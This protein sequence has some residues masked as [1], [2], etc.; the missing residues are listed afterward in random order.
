MTIF[1]VIPVVY[2]CEQIVNLAK[3]KPNILKNIAKYGIIH[4]TYGNEFKLYVK[5]NGGDLM[6]AT[7]MYIIWAVAIV[8]FG[9]LEGITFQLVSIWFMIGSVAGLVAA[10]CS[11]PF[12]L[13]VIISIAVSVLALIVTRPIVMKYLKPRIQ[14]TNADR[15]IDQWAVVLEEIDNIKSTGCVKVDG[16]EWTARSSDG[17][18]I[19]KDA[20]VTVEKIEGV[21]LIV[22]S[23]Q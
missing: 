18:V 7:T 5:S 19:P 10:L 6:E 8:G 12:Y 21:K 9:V 3:L 15:C 17:E 16:K 13:Q 1:D 4:T 23:K 20:V 11:A 14:S 22:S 2:I